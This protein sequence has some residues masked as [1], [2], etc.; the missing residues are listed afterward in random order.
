MLAISLGLSAA[1]PQGLWH[2]MSSTPEESQ[3]STK[4]ATPNEQL[5]D[6]TLVLD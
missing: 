2:H 5:N 1:T 6:G 3:V 4:S